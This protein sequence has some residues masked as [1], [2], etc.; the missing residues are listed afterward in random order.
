MSGSR[1]R[2]SVKHM[3]WCRLCLVALTLTLGCGSTMEKVEKLPAPEDRPFA[4]AW[5]RQLTDLRSVHFIDAKS[6]WAV[7]ER[8]TIVATADG[9]K[10]WTKQASG[11]TAFL[12]SVHFVNSSTGWA[13]GET[14]TVV[15]TADEGKTWT[16]Q[17]SGTNASLLSVHFVIKGDVPF[18]SGWRGS[19]LICRRTTGWTWPNKPT[20]WRILARRAPAGL[21]LCAGECRTV[22]IPYSLT[23]RFYQIRNVPQNAPSPNAPGFRTIERRRRIAH[24]TRGPRRGATLNPEAPQRPASVPGPGR[25][26]APH[27]RP[28]VFTGGEESGTAAVAPFRRDGQAQ[29]A[30]SRSPV[31]WTSSVGA[32]KR[33]GHKATRCLGASLH[34]ARACRTAH[35]H[36][37]SPDQV[38]R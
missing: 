14:G 12:R 6:G 1:T 2:P 22:Q 30:G 21:G 33:S 18:Y 3:R 27:E 15:A 7:G 35:Q 37:Q 10:T 5:Q 16:K 34:S 32:C 28:A 17:A 23:G 9:E 36:P 25:R 11:T 19:Y 20:R 29:R 38:T 24:T 13:V 26:D 4:V 8:G 31:R